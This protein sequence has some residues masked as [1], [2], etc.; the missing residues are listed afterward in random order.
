MQRLLIISLISVPIMLYAKPIWEHVEHKKHL[1][2]EG[3]S[4]IRTEAEEGLLA[5]HGHHHRINDG[6]E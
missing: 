5:G 6:S 2:Q 4:P 3:H 1:K